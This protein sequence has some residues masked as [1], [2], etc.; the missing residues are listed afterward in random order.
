MQLTAFQD[1]FS[2]ALLA[3]A[4]PDEAPQPWL[5]AM[6]AQPGFSV[7]R[8]TVLKACIDA[9]QANYPAVC[10]LVGEQWFRAAAAV[11]ARMQPPNDGRL[12]DYGAGFAGFL[13]SFEPAAELPYLP[14]VARLDRHW[15]ECHLAAD[16]P[17]LPPDWLAHQ[18]P[19]TLGQQ[20]LR[21][22]PASRWAWCDE[23]PAFT[24]WALQRDGQT[25]ETQVPWRGDGGLL[26]RPHAAVL[27]HPLPW[28]GVVFLNAC[29]SGA[30][31]EAAATQALT[32]DSHTDFSALIGLLLNAGAL[33]PL[34]PSPQAEEAA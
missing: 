20:H 7:Y 5:A 28:A 11:Y 15:T 27:W 13:Q 2:A 12:M 9:L 33:A 21:P 26:T 22:H 24:L 4:P 10:K 8:N 19:E 18:A 23:H 31:L 6:Q 29:A 16:A 1:G 32:A 17:A 3:E 30:P 34:P 14:A 25:T